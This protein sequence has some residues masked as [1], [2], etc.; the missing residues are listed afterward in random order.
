MTFR[1]F[2]I[3]LRVEEVAEVELDFSGGAEKEDVVPLGGLD[4][5]AEFLDAAAADGGAGAGRAGRG[6]G[7]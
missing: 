5:G 2:L 3:C 7:R 1:D 6:Y 4:G